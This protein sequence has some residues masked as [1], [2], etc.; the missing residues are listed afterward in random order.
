A[1]RP[2]ISLTNVLPPTLVN[3]WRAAGAG[4]TCSGSQNASPS[5]SFGHRLAAGAITPTLVLRYRVSAEAVAALELPI[6]GADV[7]SKWTVDIAANGAGGAFA[8]TYPDEVAVAPPAGSDLT[9]QA[10]TEGG[11]DAMLPALTTSAIDVSVTNLGREAARANVGL[12]GLM[13]V[14]V[15]LLGLKE[16]ASASARTPWTCTTK[17]L[18]EKD[19]EF[20][21]K[22]VGGIDI[23]PAR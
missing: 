2:A 16:R 9:V 21:C 7:P 13:P 4:W 6:G 22:P 3:G 18:N 15:Q 1:G 8:S 20:D 19:Q 14:T 12:H 10:T 23:P 5:C 11:I 17:P